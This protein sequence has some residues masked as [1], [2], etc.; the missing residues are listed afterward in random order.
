MIAVAV[1]IQAAIWT[2][3]GKSLNIAAI[4]IRRIPNREP[5]R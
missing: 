5:L 1:V 4:P 2:G 3:R